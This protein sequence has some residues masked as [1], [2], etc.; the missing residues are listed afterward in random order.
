MEAFIL[1]NVYPISPPN[2]Q[3]NVLL[4]TSSFHLA[5]FHFTPVSQNLVIPQVENPFDEPE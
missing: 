2:P 5:L 4:Y 3:L 1:Y